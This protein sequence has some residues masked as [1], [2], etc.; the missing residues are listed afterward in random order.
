MLAGLAP[1]LQWGTCLA[2]LLATQRCQGL[3][4]K[5][6][7]L[8]LPLQGR[9]HSLLQ[10]AVPPAGWPGT[11]LPGCGVCHLGRAEVGISFNYNTWL[12]LDLCVSA[13]RCQCTIGPSQTASRIPT[14][15]AFAG[16]GA[17]SLIMAQVIVTD[18]G[19][20]S[21]SSLVAA[22]ASTRP[23]HALPGLSQLACAL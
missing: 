23:I 4:K 20:V 1:A 16:R 21:H 8:P 11:S 7:P 3:S 6:L 14:L 9:V 22:Q 13:P 18:E 5:Q 15:S 19:F 12:A 17:I 10:P 2:V